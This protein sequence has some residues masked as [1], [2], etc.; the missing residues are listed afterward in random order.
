MQNCRSIT[1]KSA[2]NLAM[3]FI[4]LPR[5]K[6]DSMAALYA[7][8]RKVDD[9]ADDESVPLEERRRLLAEWRADIRRACDGAE[10]VQPVN[11]E[12]QPVI[13]RYKLPFTYFDELIRGVEMDLDIKR[14]Q[15]FDDLEQYCYRVA[16]VVGLLSIEIFG[17]RDTACR[18]YAIYLGKALQLTNILRD[19]GGDAACGRI[20][21]PL[22][23][24]EQCGVTQEEILQGKH[25]ERFV[26]AAL[27]VAGRATGFFQMARQTLPP[28][29]RRAMAA[30]EL[31]GTVY[32]H[33][34]Q[35]LKRQNFPVLGS[36]RMR[37]GRC[38]KLWLIGVAWWR[39]ATGGQQ[40][41]GTD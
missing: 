18:D 29:E 28:S 35:K 10:P 17:Y 23:L 36:K 27:Q 19:V 30:A 22:Q 39:L 14:Y 11:K 4:L 16:S 21:I 9:V 3:A 7:F 12:L 25:S 41:Y 5:E 32:W 38:H 37:L 26:Q 40:G 20:Y 31:M 15:T 34:L 13:N 24:L 6:R 33:L 8:C 1:R 2:S